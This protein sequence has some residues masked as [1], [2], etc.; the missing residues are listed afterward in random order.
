MLEQE[1]LN[2]AK[3]EV[4]LLLIH[5]ISFRTSETVTCLVIT[6]I[7]QTFCSLSTSK[8]YVLNIRNYFLSS[9]FLK[10]KSDTRQVMREDNGVIH[11][12]LLK[13]G[14]G[15]TVSQTPGP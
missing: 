3:N 4:T 11:Y 5:L 7:L 6:N 2:E 1:S 14:G 15:R 10:L 9:H 12:I 13:W 8:E